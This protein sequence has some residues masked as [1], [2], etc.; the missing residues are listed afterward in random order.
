MNRKLII[1]ILLL[2][3]LFS[4]FSQQLLDKAKIIENY[5]DGLRKG[6]NASAEESYEACLL[7]SQGWIYVMPS[8][9]SDKAAWGNKDKR[10]T[11]WLGYWYNEITNEYSETKPR[12][13]EYGIFYG[14]KNNIKGKWKNGG[15]PE[16]PDKV[17]FLL[18]KTGGPF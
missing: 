3:T 1:T 8:P 6:V 16:Y 7:K 14:D 18:S 9:K 4:M 2:F 15:S 10:T 5:K 17:M 11:W 13:N 12:Q